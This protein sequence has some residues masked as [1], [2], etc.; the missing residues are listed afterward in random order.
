MGTTKRCWLD[1]IQ[2]RHLFSNTR[3]AFGIRVVTWMTAD[4][5]W[6]RWRHSS[7]PETYTTNNKPEPRRARGSET[8]ADI[9]GLKLDSIRLR[10]ED[11]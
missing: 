3:T 4:L 11:G 9:L 6:T 2:L 7:G 1:S 10:Y 5:T 8:I